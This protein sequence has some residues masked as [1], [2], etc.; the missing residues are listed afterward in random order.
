MARNLTPDA[1][2]IIDNAENKIADGD[3][4]AVAD[5]AVEDVSQVE[6]GAGHLVG[7]RV[8]ALL[9]HHGTGVVGA[10]DARGALALGIVFDAVDRCLQ[11][12]VGG[13]HDVGVRAVA[14]QAQILVL[15]VLVRVGRVPGGSGVLDRAVDLFKSFFQCGINRKGTHRCSVGAY[16]H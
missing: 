16:G 12:A 11:R 13:R 2:E 7:A 5:V 8:G 14:G 1:K 6:G 9:D 4:A 15:V 3:G 10:G